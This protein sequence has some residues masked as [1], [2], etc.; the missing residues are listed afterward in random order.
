ML[1]LIEQKAEMRCKYTMKETINM[2]REFNVLY[3]RANITEQINKFFFLPPAFMHPV[4]SGLPL[5][6][7]I[8]ICPPARFLAKIS[9]VIGVD[10]HN[11]VMV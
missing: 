2:S 6:C 11:P 3:R 9:P 1:S 5:K 10:P 7:R 8:N 4:V